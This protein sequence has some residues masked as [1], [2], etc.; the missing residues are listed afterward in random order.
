M[1]ERLD[2]PSNGWA[3][4]RMDEPILNVEKLRLKKL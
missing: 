2:R 1:D 4:G 3:D